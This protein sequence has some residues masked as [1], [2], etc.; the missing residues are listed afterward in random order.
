MNSENDSTAAGNVWTPPTTVSLASSAN[1]NTAGG[2]P[3]NTPPINAVDPRTRTPW[4]N[5][6]NL[7]S[8]IVELTAQVGALEY[9][10]AGLTLDLDRERLSKLEWKT[11]A[12][13]LKFRLL[14]ERLRNALVASK[15]AMQEYEAE[16]VRQI[17]AAK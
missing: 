17:E 2:I 13:N 1:M 16:T 7:E 3:D 12:R 9:R 4:V 6:L 14:A 5:I 11:K 15:E 10:V 8:R